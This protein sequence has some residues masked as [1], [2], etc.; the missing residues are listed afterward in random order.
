MIYLMIHFIY[1]S[2]GL[3]WFLFGRR[4]AVYRTI[5]AVF[6]FHAV[7]LLV[8]HRETIGFRR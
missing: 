6:Q 8:S 7:K 2:I 1:I 4:K 5:E 3:P